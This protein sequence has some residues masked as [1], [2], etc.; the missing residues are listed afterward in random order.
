MADGDNH[1]WNQ[2]VRKDNSLVAL[3]GFELKV[4]TKE[5]PTEDADGATVTVT[6]F[7]HVEPTGVVCEACLTVY[8]ADA[9]AEER[10]AQAAAQLAAEEQAAV[11]EQLAPAAPLE[12]TE[13]LAS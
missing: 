12:I 10:A 9:E 3:C 4:V 13:E 2:K 7:E 5:L 6:G 11:E 1:I 8:A